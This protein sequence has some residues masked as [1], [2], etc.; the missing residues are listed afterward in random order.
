MI[1]SFV[2]AGASKRP[3]QL[4]GSD[5]PDKLNF[6]KLRSTPRGIS[7]DGA[8][9]LMREVAAM[10][11]E[12]GRAAESCIS[13]AARPVA[14]PPIGAAMLSLEVAIRLEAGLAIDIALNGEESPTRALMG[15]ASCPAMEARLAK[16]APRRENCRVGAMESPAWVVAI[17]EDAGRPKAA[18]PA[19][20]EVAMRLGAAKRNLSIPKSTPPYTLCTLSSPFS[21]FMMVPSCTRILEHARSFQSWGTSKQQ[22]GFRASP[23][24]N[25]ASSMWMPLSIMNFAMIDA[26]ATSRSCET[27]LFRSAIRSK[28]CV[29]AAAYLTRGWLGRVRGASSSP[30]GPKNCS[31]ASTPIFKQ[32]TITLSSE[33]WISA[34]LTTNHSRALHSVSKPSVSEYSKQ[35]FIPTMGCS[36]SPMDNSFRW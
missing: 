13:G 36:Y 14:R 23:T 8:D 30:F 17:S 7:D 25:H 26:L 34:C 32:G 24:P 18:R 10:S 21:A 29:K 11:E 27:T 22:V 12:A 20:T 31:R 15:A 1:R 2:S 4:P 16:G 3:A 35:L 28:C 9:M 6:S 19:T 33:T 5:A